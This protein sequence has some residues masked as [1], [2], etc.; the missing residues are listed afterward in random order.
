MA[1]M[2]LFIGHAGKMSVDVSKLHEFTI[3]VYSWA[4][5]LARDVTCHR[6]SPIRFVYVRTFECYQ[7]RPHVVSAGKAINEPELTLAN[8]TSRT[9][10]LGWTIFLGLDLCKN[11]EM[12]PVALP[13]ALSGP[14]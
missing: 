9:P 5:V 14:A 2:L 10:T 13:Q 6:P 7:V 3:R 8:S 11:R 4:A 12:L 1:R